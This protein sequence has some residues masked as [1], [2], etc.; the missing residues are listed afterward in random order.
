MQGQLQGPYRYVVVSLSFEFSSKSIN[1][2]QH[3]DVSG[4]VLEIV[5]YSV[6][7]DASFRVFGGWKE[8]RVSTSSSLPLARQRKLQIT[9]YF[10]IQ[11]LHYH[12]LK[13]DSEDYK[14]EQVRVLTS[15]AFL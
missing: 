12:K 5:M 6:P 15:L 14:L 4:M 8:K 1:T 9:R 13:S 3:F 10:T 7:R 11:M 2:N